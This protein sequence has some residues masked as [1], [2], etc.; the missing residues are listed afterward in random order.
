MAD[1]AQ[2]PVPVLVT[3]AELFWLTGGLW[4]SG[5][6]LLALLP[7]VLMP[8]LGAAA[9]LAVS[10]VAF[11]VAWQPLQRITQRAVGTTWAFVRTLALVTSAAMLAYYLRESLMDLV[12]R[13]AP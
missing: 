10:Y 3:P 6:C 7:V 12:R 11:F 5:I 1:S 8:Q 13:A 2:T 9:S 4:L